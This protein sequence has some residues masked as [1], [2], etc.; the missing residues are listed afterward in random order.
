MALVDKAIAGGVADPERLGVTGASY[1]GYSTLW[2]I[3]HTNR[4]QAAISMRPVSDLQAFYGSSDIAWNFGPLSF[5][6]EP[7]EDPD[8]FRRLS[9]VTYAD[10]MT[11]PL[12]HI[13]AT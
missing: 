11:T 8:L 2:V 6:A 5:G 12:H 3:G 10:R 13:V 4:F 7:W 9:P 1:G